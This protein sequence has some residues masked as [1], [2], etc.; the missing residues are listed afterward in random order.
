MTLAALRDDALSSTAD[1][2]ALRLSLPWIRSLPLA[3]LEAV[4]VV[5][6]G[7]RVDRLR[8]AL[9]DRL[10]DP[11]ALRQEPTWWFLQDRVV[12]RGARMLSPGVHDVAVSFRLAIPYLQAGPDGP[13][14]L[15]F[16]IERSLGL[17]AAATHPSVS[18]DVA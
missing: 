11:A 2:F 1:G 16:R 13:L 4:E 6:D 8:I 17:D 7:E 10:L 5:V 14:T 12:L 9:G 3:S 15:P 18:R